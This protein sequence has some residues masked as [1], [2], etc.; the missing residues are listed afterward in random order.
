[1]QLPILKQQVLCKSLGTNKAA[2][3]FKGSSK[4]GLQG[5]LDKVLTESNLQQ[6]AQV[7]RYKS[8]EQ[9]ADSNSMTFNCI[10]PEGNLRRLY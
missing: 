6:V 3:L 9:K 4:Q 10:F 7:F 1:M 5:A 2:D 8:K